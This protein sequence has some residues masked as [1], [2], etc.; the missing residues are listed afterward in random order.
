MK[1]QGGGDNVTLRIWANGKTQTSGCKDRGM[2]LAVNSCICQAIANIS[3]HN[4]RHNLPRVIRGDARRQEEALSHLAHIRVLSAHILGSWNVDLRSVGAKLDMGNL[5]EFLAGDRF[6]DRVFKVSLALTLSS[7]ACAPA[8][9]LL[10][11]GES[12]RERRS[13]SHTQ[14]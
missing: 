9:H 11:A 3:A 4:M 8:R 10:Y 13:H 14:V 7:V 5:C 1:V 6:G 12:W 2:L